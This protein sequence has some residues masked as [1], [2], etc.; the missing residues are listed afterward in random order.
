MI[1]GNSSNRR[2]TPGGV[3]CMCHVLVVW[4][5]MLVKEGKQTNIKQK[6]RP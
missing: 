1:I 4:V 6:S 3:A 2:A 5:W